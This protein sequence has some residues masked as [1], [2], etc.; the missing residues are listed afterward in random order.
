[1]KAIT[2]VFVVLLSALP[3]WAQAPDPAKTKASAPNYYPLKTGTR[4]EYQVDLGN[5]QKRTMVNQIAKIENIN[6]KDMARLETLMDGNVSATEHLTA[7][8]EGIFRNRFNGVEVDPPVCLLKYPVKEG[9]TWKGQTKIGD[10]Q[11]D[12]SGSEG[13]TEAVQAG[14]TNYQAATAVVE[15]TVNGMK[16]STKYWFAPDVGIVK[17]SLEFGGRT[18]NME[19]V[20]FQAGR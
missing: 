11:L 1:M 20:K 16:I 17:Q 12:I 6:G 18:I 13:K 3:G 2:G 15:T 8:N 4:W 14:G 5:N 9:T 7:T 10:Q 19:L